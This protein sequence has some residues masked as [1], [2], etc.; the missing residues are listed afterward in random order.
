MIQHSK[1]F[2]D[3]ERY[4]G[5]KILLVGN[6]RSGIDLL[7][8]IYRDASQVFISSRSEK[9]VFP[10]LDRASKSEGIIAKPEVVSFNGETGE[11]TFK[12]GS[13]ESAF[14]SILYSTG[15]HYHFPFIKDIVRIG[16]KYPQ[17]S[18]GD[19]VK[20]LYLQAFPIGQPRLAI[21]GTIVF[22]LLFH[23]FEATAAAVAGVFS[24]A[25]TLP[26]IDEQR[27]WEE[28]RVN[29][30]GDTSAFHLYTVEQGKEQLIDK[31]I[32]IAPLNRPN[33]LEV[34][35]GGVEEYIW[36][37][38]AAERLFYTSKAKGHMYLVQKDRSI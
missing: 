12:D 11:V 31:L 20:G 7:R 4:K 8:Y 26:P 34:D 29:I 2:R 9:G 33:P 32:A 36:S 10:W 16:S 35:Q 24:G 6:N 25:T 27:K 14:D 13:V 18:S 15:Y 37:Q 1:A 30:T 21:V 3:P 19:R 22:P 28:D 38:E 17:R 5:Q 23:A